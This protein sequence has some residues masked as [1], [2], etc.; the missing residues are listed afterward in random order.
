M[1]VTGLIHQSLSLCSASQ[2]CFES[3]FKLLELSTDIDNV[4]DEITA[5]DIPLSCRLM[6]AAAVLMLIAVLLAQAPVGEIKNRLK[7]RS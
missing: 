1:C 4:L 7:T 6:Y 5:E 3:D 2:H